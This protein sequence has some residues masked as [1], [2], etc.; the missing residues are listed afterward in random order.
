MIG[1]ILQ[2]VAALAGVRG[3]SDANNANIGM[4][5]ETNAQ[6]IA[7]AQK[8]RDYQTTASQ[9]EMDFTERMSNTAKQREVA[10]L[11]AAGLN[12]ILAANSGAST[13]GGASGSGA[14]PT[15]TAPRAENIYAGLANSAVQAARMYQDLKMQESN[16]AINNAQAKLIAAQTRKTGIDSKVSEK[17]LPKSE[18][19]NDIYDVI[20]PM[21]QKAKDAFTPPASAKGVDRQSREQSIKNSYKL[22]TMP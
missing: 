15:L 12:P 16:I 8:N 4:A 19:M 17:D 3:Q 7:E 21:V 2:G 18:F 1:E 11:K 10:D 20:R 14:T 13:P 22:Q 5:R 9:K 6:A